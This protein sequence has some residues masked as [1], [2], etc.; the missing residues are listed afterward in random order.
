[1]KDYMGFICRILEEIDIC[2]KKYFDLEFPLFAD[3]LCL[4]S[5]MRLLLLGLSEMFYGRLASRQK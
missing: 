4:W 3:L 1:M 5:E 2:V